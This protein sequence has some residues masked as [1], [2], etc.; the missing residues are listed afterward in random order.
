MRRHME[1]VLES[2]RQQVA[3]QETWH[4]FGLRAELMDYWGIL[5]PIFR[6]NPG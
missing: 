2:Y 3:P 1:S 4:L 5:A 6:W